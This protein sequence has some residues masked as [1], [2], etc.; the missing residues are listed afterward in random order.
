MGGGCQ[1]TLP[2]IPRYLQLKYLTEP[3]TPLRRTALEHG[4]CHTCLPQ[5]PSTSVTWN[6]LP[7]H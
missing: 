3:Q 7:P 6:L 2:L 5:I 1:A 4:A